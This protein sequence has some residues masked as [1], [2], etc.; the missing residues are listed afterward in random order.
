MTLVSKCVVFER[1][2]HRFGEGIIRFERKTVPST[3]LLYAIA[4]D[5][6][7]LDS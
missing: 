6:P 2:E 5:T 4:A 7:S 3:V 1:Y